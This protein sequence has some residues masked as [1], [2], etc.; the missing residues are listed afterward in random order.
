MLTQNKKNEIT[1]ILNEK[2][3]ML[4]CPM[5]HSRYFTLIDGYFTNPI[6]DD[7][8]PIVIGSGQQ[9][10]YIAIVCDN[11]GFISQH[12]LGVLNLLE[13]KDK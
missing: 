13:K 4:E 12:A 8:H 5:C 9:V 10:P 7:F 2:I 3:K 1:S 11:C 6:Q